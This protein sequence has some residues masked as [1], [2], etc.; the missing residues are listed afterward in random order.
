M[1]FNEG[2]FPYAH[3]SP[4]PSSATVELELFRVP[5][6]HIPNPTL[7]A[8]PPDVAPPPDAAPPSPPAAPPMAVAQQSRPQPSHS[9]V[10]QLKDEISQ[11]KIR[12]DGTV[13]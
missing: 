10:T 2:H 5:S 1:V 7:A 6:I 9:M 12:T 3:V 8:P 11:P 4:A 13:H